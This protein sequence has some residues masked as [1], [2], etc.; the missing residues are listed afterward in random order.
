MFYFYLL[1][2]EW[3]HWSK[4]PKCE[5]IIHIM[6]ELVIDNSVVFNNNHI[7]FI[8]NI[9]GKVISQFALKFASNSTHNV[10]HTTPNL[11]FISHLSVFSLFSFEIQLSTFSSASTIF[12]DN[13]F[14]FIFK[15]FFSHVQSYFHKKIHVH[16]TGRV[17]MKY[18][19]IRIIKKKNKTN[20]K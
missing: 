11:V 14:H 9:V 18:L 8:K 7:L 17:V 2:K 1:E 4:M 3:F 6:C 20:S 5:K 15:C 12:V 13:F 10:C 19:H 16:Q